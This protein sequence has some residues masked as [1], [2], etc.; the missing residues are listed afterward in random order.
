[1]VDGINLNSANSV[2]NSSL[3][4]VSS[5]FT[6][7]LIGELENRL[8]K[9]KEEL[10]KIEE[11]KT[12]KD[13]MF[14]MLDMAKS[15]RNLALMGVKSLTLDETFVKFCQ[16]KGITIPSWGG[17]RE[18][19]EGAWNQFVDKIQGMVDSLG[20]NMQKSLEKINGQTTETR[21]ISKRCIGGD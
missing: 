6:T 13:G 18:Q 15:Y 7:T 1:M 9:L 11:L 5:D 19:L 10:T 8:Q 20:N 16:D 4:A 3:A 12:Q 14:Q 21:F 2:Q 17:N